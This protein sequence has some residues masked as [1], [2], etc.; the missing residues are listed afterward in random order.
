M[1]LAIDVGNTNLRLGVVRDSVLG[2]P[3]RAATPAVATPDEVETL[4][5][6]LLA[7]DGLRLDEVGAFVVSSTVPAATAAVE[8]LASRRAVPCLTASAVTVPLPIR[9]ERP[10]DVGPDRLVNAYAAAHLYG[11]PAVVVDCGTATTLDAVDHGGAFVGGAIAPGLGMGL[12]ALA[13]R[14]ARLPR[15]TPDLPDGPIGRDTVAAIRAGTVLGHRA[16]IEGL[17]GQMRR[18]LAA[19]AD[20]APREVRVV[21]TGGLAALPWARTIEGIGAIDPE[22]TLRGLVLV[23]RA[24]TGAQGALAGTMEA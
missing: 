21:L 20:L 22:L 16:M 10:D 6:S 4:L 13:A 24:V 1:L 8:G 12:E 7:L 19:A 5:G 17:L 3:R 2:V 9:V 11:V 14:T 15:V 23:H 18:Q